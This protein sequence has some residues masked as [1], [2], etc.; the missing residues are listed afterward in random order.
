M[1][2]YKQQ[3]IDNPKQYRDDKDEI[4]LEL[5][6]AEP[7]NKFGLLFN[8][9]YFFYKTWDGLNNKAKYFIRKYNLKEIK[10]EKSINQ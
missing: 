3:L 1:T 10:T 2:T 9:Q 5:F 7:L 8:G 6:Y 4:L